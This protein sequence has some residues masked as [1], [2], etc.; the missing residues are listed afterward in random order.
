M[1]LHRNYKNFDGNLLRS[2]HYKFFDTSL[3]HHYT[4]AFLISFQRFC[5]EMNAIC[6]VMRHFPRLVSYN[7]FP[8]LISVK[9]KHLFLET[10]ILRAGKIFRS[11]LLKN[12]TDRRNKVL[13]PRHMPKVS[14]LRRDQRQRRQERRAREKTESAVIES[15]AR[16]HAS[17]ARRAAEFFAVTSSA[18]LLRRDEPRPTSD[19]TRTCMTLFRLLPNYGFHEK[20]RG[21][22]GRRLSIELTLIS[23]SPSNLL[24]NY[25]HNWHAHWP[26]TVSYTHLTLPTKRIV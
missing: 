5:I 12:M 21:G 16:K 1:L 14:G 3:L 13:L 9:S 10:V 20:R 23:F 26:L 17:L 18:R 7:D 15:I 25:G 11:H 19:P 8:L 6:W 24:F 22:E 4:V 2:R